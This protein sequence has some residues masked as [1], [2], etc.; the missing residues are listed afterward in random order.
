MVMPSHVQPGELAAHMSF[1]GPV[2]LGLFLV[3]IYVIT[4]LR[5][6]APGPLAAAS[7]RL[8][9]ARRRGLL[10]ERA[11]NGPKKDERGARHEEPEPR[12]RAFLRFGRADH[13]AQARSLRG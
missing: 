11:G 13:A 8:Q 4:L 12:R 6:I 9:L 3:F 7:L 1:T 2:S 5:K 10:A